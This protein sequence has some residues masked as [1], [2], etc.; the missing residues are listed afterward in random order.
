MSMRERSL[1][2]AAKVG[3]LLGSGL[4]MTQPAGCN[5]TETPSGDSGGSVGVRG[6]APPGGGGSGGAGV[7]GGRGGLGP[8]GGAGGVTGGVGGVCGSGCTSSSTPSPFC[9]APTVLLL[10]QPPISAERVGILTANG[11]SIAEME[12]ALG[13][14]CPPEILTQCV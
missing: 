3:L 13:F 14:C 7:S 11:C 1:L 10:C 2:F 4:L 6:G 8:T 9:A 12:G 5:G